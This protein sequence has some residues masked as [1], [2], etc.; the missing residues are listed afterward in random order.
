MAKLD[1]LLEKVMAFTTEEGSR[2]LVW[3]AVGGH[4]LPPREL[5]G[6]YINRAAV[7]EVSDFILSKEGKE[8]QDRIWV[9]FFFAFLQ[10]IADSDYAF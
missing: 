8:A 9:S 10:A 4:N 7:T 6:A 3:G 5:H 1:K 2:A